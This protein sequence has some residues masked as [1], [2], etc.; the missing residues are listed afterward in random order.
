MGVDCMR[1]RHYKYEMY[2]ISLCQKK[3]FDPLFIGLSYFGKEHSTLNEK[4]KKG[5]VLNDCNSLSL[6]LLPVKN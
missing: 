5:V 1:L 3:I 2:Q 6:P 4:K